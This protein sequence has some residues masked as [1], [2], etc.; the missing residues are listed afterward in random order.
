[1]EVTARRLLVAAAVSVIL[2]TAAFAQVAAPDL[3]PALADRINQLGA[4]H[5]A[6]GRLEPAEAAIVSGQLLTMTQV[7]QKFEAA[8]PGQTFGDDFV[9]IP[10]A[11]P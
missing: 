3:A 4:C 7:R 10:K 1:M 11:T 2:A 6:L 5:T 9:L 8:N